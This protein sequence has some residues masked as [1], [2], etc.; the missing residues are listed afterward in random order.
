MRLLL[1]RLLN[2]YNNNNNDYETI[3]NCDKTFLKIFLS[4]KILLQKATTLQREL[5]VI[6]KSKYVSKF[7]SI[8]TKNNS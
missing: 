8:N 6:I 2:N 4:L 7:R 5:N 3:K 1:I